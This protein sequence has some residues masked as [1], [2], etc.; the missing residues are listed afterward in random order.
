MADPLLIIEDEELLGNELARFFS[1]QG[2]DVQVAT[3]LAEAR[4][5]LYEDADESMVVLADMSLPDGN[6][7]DLLE[8]VRAR[9]M[10][11]E[12]VL[13]TG[14]GTV[15][16]SVRALKLGALDFLAKPCSTERLNVVLNGARRGANAQGRLHR[17]LAEGSRRYRPESFIGSSP[18]AAEVREMVRRLS[19]SPQRDDH[20]WRDRHRQGADRPDPASFRTGRRWTLDRSQLRGA[21]ARP[22]GV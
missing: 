16:D 14:Y 18:Q 10:P 15:P 1:R 20:Q 11:V 2:W 8:E 9:R 6:S 7:L 3:R 19:G 12:W 21:A 4:E 22:G 13:L 17:Q 5:L